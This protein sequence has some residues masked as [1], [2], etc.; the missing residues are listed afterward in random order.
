MHN[1]D[2]ISQAAKAQVEHHSVGFN[3]HQQVLDEPKWGH[4]NFSWSQQKTTNET[5]QA[6]G[7]DSLHCQ[8]K[9]RYISST[10]DEHFEMFFLHLKAEKY[11][12]EYMS[13][14]AFIL[15]RSHPVMVLG[16]SQASLPKERLAY[17][18]S[19]PSAL[20]LPP[21][22]A[23]PEPKPVYLSEILSLLYC[24]IVSHSEPFWREQH[25][26]IVEITE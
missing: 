21:P 7:T 8:T 19:L 5:Y 16:S 26:K 15:A 6:Q 12:Y 25:K 11:I 24:F 2:L 17:A 14:Q 23:P 4:F 13:E 3:S 1:R 20:E 18:P 10:T 9:S 22:W